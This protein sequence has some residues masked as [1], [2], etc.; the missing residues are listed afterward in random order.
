MRKSHWLTRI[1]D[2][3]NRFGSGSDEGHSVLKHSFVFPSQMSKW[4]KMPL[5]MQCFMMHHHHHHNNSCFRVQKWFHKWICWAN[6]LS[7][8][9]RTCLNVQ[10]IN[11]SWTSVQILVA[12]HWCS[13]VSFYHTCTGKNVFFFNKVVN[14]TDYWSLLIQKILFRLSKC[15]NQ[16]NY[17]W[18]FLVIS[19]VKSF[20]SKSWPFW[21]V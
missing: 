12:S 5:H 15:L 20:K 17:L 4:D 18:N 10:L 6:V 2:D 19:K 1:S 7:A 21:C 3:L 13:P 11:S 8:D 9:K 16:C 14:I